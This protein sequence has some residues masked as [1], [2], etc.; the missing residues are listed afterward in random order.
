[1]KSHAVSIF[2]HCHVESKYASSHVTRDKKKK[3]E[4]G[5]KKMLQTNLRSGR[6]LRRRLNR[7]G[8]VVEVHRHFG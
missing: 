3:E 2:G 1:M 6:L 4:V 5:T 7:D 8:S